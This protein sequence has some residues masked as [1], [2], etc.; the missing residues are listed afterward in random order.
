ML[1]GGRPPAPPWNT[2]MNNITK[3]ATYRAA[4]AAKKWKIFMA[5]K[6]FHDTY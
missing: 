4:I 3:I 6:D 1:G 5:K 2:S